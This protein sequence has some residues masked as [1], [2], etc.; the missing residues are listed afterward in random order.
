M[1]FHKLHNFYAIET[2]KIF[3]KIVGVL[4]RTKHISMNVTSQ[5]R[6]FLIS[7]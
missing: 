3:I 1:K 4:K 5:K 2:L 7:K 6:L